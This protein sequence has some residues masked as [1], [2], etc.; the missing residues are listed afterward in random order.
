MDAT[1]IAAWILGP[2][3]LIAGT[4]LLHFVAGV[5]NWLSLALLGSS[6]LVLAGFGRIS[7][8]ATPGDAAPLA[9]GGDGGHKGH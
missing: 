2:A 1:G 6:L 9:P 3:A 4:Y 8:L 5:N 7:R